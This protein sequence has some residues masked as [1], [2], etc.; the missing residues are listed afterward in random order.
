MYL[1]RFQ[2]Y[3][4]KRESGAI[5]GLGLRD[6]EDHLDLQVRYKWFVADGS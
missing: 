1:M 5:Q 3:R 4:E 6:L 2:V